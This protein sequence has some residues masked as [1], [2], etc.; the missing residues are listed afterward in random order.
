[1]EFQEKK[2]KNRTL[3]HAYS[4]AKW[5]VSRLVPMKGEDVFSICNVVLAFTGA[6]Q[7]AHHSVLLSF[8]FIFICF[9]VF[10]VK[11]KHRR[12]L[13]KIRRSDQKPGY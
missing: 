11:S 5:C 4:N 7:A 1:M 9:M 8:G 13:C 10:A 2:N 6:E 3:L 12:R